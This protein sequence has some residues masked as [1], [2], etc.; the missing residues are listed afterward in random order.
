MHRDFRLHV[1]P[2]LID[3]PSLDFACVLVVFLCF[4]FFFS[5]LGILHSPLVCLFLFSKAYFSF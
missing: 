2:T 1:P 5:L 4:F 3:S